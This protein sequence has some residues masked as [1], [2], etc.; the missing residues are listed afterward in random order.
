MSD[1]IKVTDRDGNVIGFYCRQTGEYVPM[2]S[3]TLTS[4]T[5]GRVVCDTHG[6][7]RRFSMDG[8][9]L[10]EAMEFASSKPCPKERCPDE[11]T[12]HHVRR[13]EFSHK[14]DSSGVNDA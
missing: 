13:I 5:S 8:D 12:C 3:C 7:I 9:G 2:D 4:K 6:E 11:G 14:A 10:R 1:H